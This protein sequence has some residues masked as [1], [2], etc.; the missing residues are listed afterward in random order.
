VIATLF[1]LA[2][3]LLGGGLAFAYHELLADEPLVTATDAQLT[4][5]RRP[6]GEYE[7]QSQ[8]RFWLPLCDSGDPMCTSYIAGL[9]E[10]QN[11]LRSPFFCPRTLRL[12]E[13]EAIVVKRLRYLGRNAPHLLRYPMLVIASHVL[14]RQLPCETKI[15][16]ADREG[17][18]TIT[19]ARA[20]DGAGPVQASERYRR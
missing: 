14:E 15:A 18:S 5:R 1:L 16:Q 3:L 4:L 6:A 12:A 10:M 2:G 11:G 20:R 7:K 19:R 17:F 8:A 9:V 13:V